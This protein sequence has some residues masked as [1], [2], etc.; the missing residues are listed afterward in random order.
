MQIKVQAW[1]KAVG[2]QFSDVVTL[3]TNA[4]SFKFDASASH[5]NLK[6][7]EPCMVEWDPTATKRK[8]SSYETW[9][10]TTLVNQHTS[11]PFYYLTN[12]NLP[13]EFIAL[14]SHSIQRLNLSFYWQ[15]VL[16]IL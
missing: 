14:N 3:S 16:K 1:N 2:G 13:G 9:K 4:F 11:N 5:G 12:P 8:S 10:F 15:I 7:V 6:V